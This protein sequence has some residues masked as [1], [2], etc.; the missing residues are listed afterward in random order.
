MLDTQILKFKKKIRLEIE[1]CGKCACLLRAL[2]YDVKLPGPMSGDLDPIQIKNSF[3]NT[4][5]FTKDPGNDSRFQ[6][7]NF[8]KTR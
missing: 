5:E 7:V 4:M 3:S 8:E 1:N 2:N 6:C